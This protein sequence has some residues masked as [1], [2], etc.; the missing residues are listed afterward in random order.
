[1][2]LIQNKEGLVA[3][4]T[5]KVS[6]EDY[7][8]KVEKELRKIR[9]TSQAKGFRPGNVPMSLI[10]KMYG[11]PLMAEEVNRLILELL[12]GYE[13][14]N[15]GRIFAPVIPSERNQIMTTYDEQKDFEFVYEAG[16]FPEFTYEIDENTELPYYNIILDDKDVDAEIE[17]YC[18]MYCTTGNVE[19]IED[20]CLVSADV[21][22]VKGEE[23]VTHSA[24]FLVSVIP[25][26]YKQVFFGVKVNETVDVEIRK[27]FTSE[28]DLMGMLKVNKDELELLPETLAF[29]ITKI[30]KRTPAQINQDLFDKVAGENTIHSEEELREYARNAII[31]DYNAMSL[32][33][34]FKDSIEI[35]L[36]KTN[37]DMPEA[38]IG[39]YIRYIQKEG[40]EISEETFEQAVKYFVR[41]SRCKYIMSSLLAQNNIQVTYNSLRE[42][43]KA[44]LR[45]NYPQHSD[46]YSD[47]EITRL[48]DIY[49]QNEEHMQYLVKRVTNKQFASLLKENAKLNVQ[50]LTL[51]EF[52]KIY[53]KSKDNTLSDTDT[54]LENNAVPV[55]IGKD[56][57]PAI[58]EPETAIEELETENTETE[59][60][61]NNEEIQL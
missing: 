8:A 22:L 56:E 38:F 26:E 24:D 11:T 42:E 52:Q 6:Q 9:Q 31:T 10:K 16:F 23:E 61:N 4:L 39:K 49:Q 34:L 18:N 51:E 36:E 58:E 40:K 20:D 15:A 19:A 2:E 59:N 53:Y 17:G 43:I 60:N 44:L 7:V 41:E 25:D 57:T 46:Y 13:Q 29:T 35:L 37:I 21:N 33:K 1:M 55:E 54:I 48:L 3:T 12:K 27:V 5:V 32:N 50:D 14:E 47:E 30:E 45:E 28:V